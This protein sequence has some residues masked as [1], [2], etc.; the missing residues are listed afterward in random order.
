MDR[1]SRRRFVRGVSA[2]SL[3]ALANCNRTPSPP[4]SPV[5]HSSSP[6]R[7]GFLSVGSPNDRRDLDA[8]LLGLREL[9]Y[10]ENQTLMVEPRYARDDYTSLPALASELV[11]GGV[12]VLVA[13]GGTATQA[14]KQA[15]PRIPIVMITGS[16]PVRAGFVESLAHPGGNITGPASITQALIGKRLEFL[17]E[18]VPDCLHVGA[19][20]NADSYV[21]GDSITELESAAAALGLELQARSVR[22]RDEFE[23]A[24][25]VLTKGGVQAFTTIPSGMLLSNGAYIAELCLRYRLP[26]M[27]DDARF[28]ADGGMMAYGPNQ[29]AIVQR[30]AYYVDRILK[31]ARPADL[32]VERPT[33]FDLVINRRIAQ[34][35]G[36]TI[37]QHMLLQ[38]TEVLD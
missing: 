19:L 13:S 7:V 29:A 17:K 10:K 18:T 16:D 31:G 20:W 4:L 9:G 11:R 38:A 34:A 21:E 30:A 3:L 25:T 28:V 33:R 5:S 27:F 8:L 15:A 22:H 36:L 23:E 37:P 24:F 2:V 1:W 32:P 14:A 12:A 6:P 26:S 35:L